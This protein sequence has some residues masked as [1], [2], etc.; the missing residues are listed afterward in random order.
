MLLIRLGGMVNRKIFIPGESREKECSREY[1]IVS[2]TLKMLMTYKS[3]YPC[4]CAKDIEELFANMNEKD[5]ELFNS[6]E[7]GEENI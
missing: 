2:N 1:F 6:V 5:W 3:N 7:K 4:L